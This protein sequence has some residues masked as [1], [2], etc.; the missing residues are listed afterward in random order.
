MSEQDEMKAPQPRLCPRCG[1]RISPDSIRCQ[2]CGTDLRS[3]D[4]TR[5][6]GGLGEV[7]LSLPLAI[8]L[9]ALFALLSAGLTFAAVRFVGVGQSV[10]ETPTPSSTPTQ[11]ATL[12]PTATNTPLPTPTPQ[13]PIEHTVQA[14]ETCAALAAFYE[15]SV[16]AIVGLN[17]LTPECLLSVGQTLLIPRPT[18]TPTP[19]PTATLSPAEA[20]EAACEKLPYTVQANDTL[21]G[22]AK[23]YNVEIRGI[24][25]YNGMVN[26][27]IFEGQQLIIP[28]CRRVPTPGPTPTP[29]P[30]PPYPAPNLLLPQDGAAFTLAH[31]TVT[32][33]WASV[34]PLRENEYYQVNVL[35]VT[36]GSG[37]KR[38]VEYVKD[39]KFIV[40]VSL[41]PSE[42]L[43]HVIRWWVIP[44]RQIGTKAGG[45][46][47]YE[48]AGSSS[49]KR[50]FTWSGAAGGPTPTP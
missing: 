4:P 42:E 31:D 9:L 8:G 43:P 18:P 21:S 17:N 28:L 23:Y 27:T 35:D 1:T 20:T 40:P 19:L 25:D 30:P 12:Q 44:M 48:S 32:L 6:L 10:T 38:I 26:E 22:I 37:T 14:N 13:P 41:R 36:E 46:P 5:G 24:M 47:I 50:D 29:T 33:Q 49:A 34:G 3:D 39:T 45:E 15:V 2:V 11:T 7:T 16:Q